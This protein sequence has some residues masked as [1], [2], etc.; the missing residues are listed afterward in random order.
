MMNIGGNNQIFLDGRLLESKDKVRIEVQSPKKTGEKNL[1]IGPYTYDGLGAKL[2]SGPEFH[3]VPR[4]MEY[5]GIFK[6]FGSVSDDGIDWV[7]GTVEVIEEGSFMYGTSRY[8]VFTDPKAPSEERYKQFLESDLMAS[9]DGLEWKKI[10]KDIWPQEALFPFG[11]DSNNIC[12]YDER[13]DKYVAYVRINKREALPSQHE[14][15]YDNWDFSEG[16][17]IVRCVGRSETDSL[18]TFP[19]PEIVLEPDEEDP[20]MDGVAVMDFY[21]PEVYKYPYAQDA[22]LGFPNTFLHYREWYLSEDLRKYKF[23]EVGDIDVGG[24]DIKFVGSHDGIRWERY[25]RKPIIALGEKEQFD[26]IGMYPVHGLFAHGDEIWMYYVGS[27]CHTAPNEDIVGFRNTMSR[28]IFRRDGFTC[29]EADYTGG[30]FTTPPLTF[31]GKELHLNIDTSAIGIAR[32]EIQD[33]K[34]KPI[35]GHALADCD[36]IHTTNSID[37]VVS[38]RSKSTVSALSGRPVRLRFELRFGARLFSF[39]IAPGE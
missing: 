38:W 22:Y 33:E 18:L 16:A 32:V 13:I 4:I 29:V 14:A 23:N 20:V 8:L 15:Y 12:F 25:D 30:E 11:M 27:S 34:G 35:E 3:S 5:D 31:D 7:P 2:T 39:R 17:N 1:T 24:M 21:N 28:V 19:V 10:G 26:Q 37:R 6:G 9:K 36:R